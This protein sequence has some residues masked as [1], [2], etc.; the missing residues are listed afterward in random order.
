MA[1][2]E[3]VAL[4]AA[5]LAVVLLVRWVRSRSSRAPDLSMHRFSRA[6]DAISPGD[7]QPRAETDAQEHDAQEHDARP[8]PSNV[9]TAAAPERATPE[10]H[11]DV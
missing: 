11:G 1:V 7:E 5:A 4:V 3:I 2:N 10:D 9:T 6:L 8:V